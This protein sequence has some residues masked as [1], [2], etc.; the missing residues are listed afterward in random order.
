MFKGPYKS[1]AAVSEIGEFGGAEVPNGWLSSIFRSSPSADARMVTTSPSLGNYQ[2][3][4]AFGFESS[5]PYRAAQH[6]LGQRKQ[7]LGV[8][9]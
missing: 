8:T 9:S 3:T 4:G 6:F 7:D 1:G 5:S 2:Y